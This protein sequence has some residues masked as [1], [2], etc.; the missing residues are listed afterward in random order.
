MNRLSR[1]SI[2]SFMAALLLV[3]SLPSAALATTLVATPDSVTVGVGSSSTSID[4]L[5]NDSGDAIALTGVTIPGHGTATIDGATID[6]TPTPAFRGTD[7]FDYTIE[8]QAAATATATVTVIVND[9]PVALDD[10]GIPC[11]SLA[12]FGGAFPIP[13]DYRAQ[14]S[15]YQFIPDQD[16][17]FVL[18]GNCGLLRNDT[19]PNG[20]PLTYEILTQPA[21]GQAMK[22]DE[23]FFGYKPNPDFGTLEGNLPGGQ[24]VS[25]SFTYRA[26]DGLSYSQPATMRFWVAQ[27]NDPPT[28]TP[29]PGTVT[30]GEDSGHYSAPWASNVSPGPNESYQTVEFRLDGPDQLREN[31]NKELFIDKPAIDGSGNLTFTLAPGAYGHASVTMIA[32]DDGGMRAFQGVSP[33]KGP[34]DTSDAFSFV[35]DVT[36]DGMTLVDDFVTLPEDPTPSPW[37]MSVLSN[38]TVPVGSTITAVTQGT[39]GTATVSPAGDALLYTPN[40]NVSGPDSVTY[41]VDDHHGHTHTATVHILVTPTNDAPDAVDDAATIDPDSPPT[42]IDVLANDSDIDGD[43]VHILSATNGAHGTVAVDGDGTGLTYDPDQG[44]TGPDAFT[45]VAFDGGGLSDTATVHVT[46]THDTTPPVVVAPAQRFLGQTVGTSSIKGR[47]AWSASDPGSGVA[48]YDLEVSVDGGGYAAVPL[49]SPMSTSVDRPLTVGS[50]YRFRVRATDSVGNASSWTYGA[51]FRPAVY[52]ETTSLAAY[53]GAWSTSKSAQAL[54]GGYRWTSVSGRTVRFHVTAS[55]IGLVMTKTATSGST[56][57][58]VDG[59]LAGAINLRATKT[60]Y[61]QLV[62]VRH[63]ATLGLHTVELRPTGTGR[64]DLDAFATLH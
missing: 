50:S 52:Q 53:T 40:L 32:K 21:H 51:A 64:V 7:T 20:D 54:G 44:Y 49:A 12:N 9:P 16:Y 57:V 42:A 1:R 35:I 29:G 4:V 14:P 60:T 34:D 58:Y 17:W 56:Q 25:D 33:T 18:F 31:A 41:T 3:G 26:F 43:A 30:V 62:F 22:I 19:D 46:V 55:D 28:F 27:I 36:W 2:G 11:G 6:Y 59:V 13:E 47:I 24:W 38:D 45:Y 61:R 15:G 39:I 8:D 23:S 48:R 5:A 63:F 37:L 10:P